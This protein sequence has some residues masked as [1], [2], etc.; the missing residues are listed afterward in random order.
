LLETTCK[1]KSSSAVAPW[2]S[3]AVILISKLP[4]SGV[5]GVPL[6]LRL[7]ALK[8]TFRRLTND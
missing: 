6:K 4:T 2:L 3:I 7:L 5:P 1:V 8:P